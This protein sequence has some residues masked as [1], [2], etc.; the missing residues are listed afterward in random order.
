MK[1]TKETWEKRHLI[2]Y[3]GGGGG[4]TSGKREREQN[5]NRGHAIFPLH[6]IP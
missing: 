3:E 5:G 6:S 1:E 2:G 4:K